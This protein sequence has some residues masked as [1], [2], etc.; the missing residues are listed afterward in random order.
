M[1]ENDI[2]IALNTLID[3]QE[4]IGRDIGKVKDHLVVLNHRTEKL[5]LQNLEEKIR[6]EV[7]KEW[8]RKENARIEESTKFSRFWIT[9]VLAL[10]TVISSGVAI[11][12]TQ[13]F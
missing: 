8:Q 9:T 7:N 3:K 11:V 2:S 10:M 13:V 1:D 12:V 4:Y 6:S 5:E